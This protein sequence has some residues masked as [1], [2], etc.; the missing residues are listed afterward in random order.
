ME[1]GRVTMRGSQWSQGESQWGGGAKSFD[2]RV[3][4]HSKEEKIYYGYTLVT[5]FQN[6]VEVG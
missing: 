4:K 2:W 3:T 1:P 6:T 5:W